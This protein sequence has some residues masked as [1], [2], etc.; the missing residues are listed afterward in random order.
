MTT[1]C[2]VLLFICFV[3]YKVEKPTFHRSFRLR[4]DI[5]T[6]KIMSSEMPISTRTARQE[7]ATAVPLKSKTS[8][9]LLKFSWLHGFFQASRLAILSLR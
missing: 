9:N 2:A 3:C 8:L 7:K 4:I 1:W 6:L 5:S